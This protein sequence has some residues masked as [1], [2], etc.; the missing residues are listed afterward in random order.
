MLFQTLAHI[1]E[2]SSKKK[3]GTLNH[4]L[5]FHSHPKERD[6]SDPRIEV[7]KAAFSENPSHLEGNILSFSSIATNP[8]L[9]L[10]KG[11]IRKWDVGEA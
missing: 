8:T 5:G 11:T 6:C 10:E 4:T 3:A 1:L 9:R 2:D 7:E